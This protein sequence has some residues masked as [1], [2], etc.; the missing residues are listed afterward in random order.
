M[1]NGTAVRVAIVAVL[2]PLTFL[3][4][5]WLRASLEPPGTDMPDWTFH[6]MPK[7]L[8]NWH[9]EETKM[10]P[11]IAVLT[12][13]K[14]D[15]IIQRT[16]RDDSG[17]AVAV[18]AAMFDNPATGVMHTPLICYFAAGWTKLS[19]QR[20][21]LQLPIGLTKLSEKLTIPI[22]IT[23]WESEK[24]NRKVIVVYWYQL[25]EHFL[26]GRWDLGVKIR[27]SLAGKPTWPTLI[28][29]MMEMPIIEGEDA[30]PTVLGFAEQVAG[31]ANKSPHRNGKGMLGVQTGGSSAAAATNP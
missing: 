10:D 16:Y 29:V 3:G 11:R 21:Y 26:F 24:E 27:W 23:T 15:T 18:H 7:Q 8:G 22:S 6:D 4:A 20:G 14:L 9:G 31:W 13:A 19:E 2:L 28:K 1:I 30:K 25:G 12:G 5:N 17:H